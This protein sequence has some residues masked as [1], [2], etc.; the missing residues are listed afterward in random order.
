[1]M[2]I[3]SLFQ[4]VW[5]FEAIFKR[6]AKIREILATAL[7]VAWLGILGRALSDLERMLSAL[8][9]V[10]DGLSPGLWLFLLQSG[11]GG[12]G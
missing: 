1:M 12:K 10:E 6:I 2:A 5:D 8:P 7:I 11:V 4:W 9:I 3:N